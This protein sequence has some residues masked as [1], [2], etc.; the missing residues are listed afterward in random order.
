MVASYSEGKTACR[1]D[2]YSCGLEAKFMQMKDT[3]Y[4]HAQVRKNDWIA[5]GKIK[6]H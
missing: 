1:P 5:N 2:R 4:A 3:N 6:T